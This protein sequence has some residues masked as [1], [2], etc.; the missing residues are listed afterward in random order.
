MALASRSIDEETT[1]LADAY[2]SLVAPKR[3]WRNHN[4][5]LYLILRSFAAGKVGLVDAAIALRNRYSP[6]YCDDIDLYSTAKLVGTDFKQGTG[7]VVYIT[8]LNK[9][10]ANHR[11]L[12]AGIYSYQAVSGTV[13][14]FR[15]RD[16]YVFDP[17][18]ER[19]IAAVSE[20]KGSFPVMQNANIKVFRSD[21]EKISPSFSFSC[22]DNSGLLGY[23][24]ETPL[25]F[26][27]R[28]LGDADRQDHIKELELKIR[29]LP[30]IFECSLVFNESIEPQ[31]YDGIVLGGKELL[32]TITGEPTDEIADLVAR[33]VVYATHKVRDDDVVYCRNELYINGKYPVYFRY[34]DTTDFSLAIAYQYD[35]SKLKPSQVEDAIKALFRGYRRTVAHIDAFSEGDAYKIL[36]S[37]NL[38]NVKILDASVINS[39]GEEVP[40][41]RVPRTRLPRLTG[42]Q[43]SAVEIGGSM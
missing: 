18:E 7:S 30:G 5:K 26:R 1:E 10:T 22:D 19:E 15:V 41:V 40:F 2:D 21:G 8:I 24:D 9:D 38:P 37:L 27:A 20:E 6:L 39:G 42:I 35:Q 14:R 33:E 12:Y 11:T 31:E 36:E 23:A 29:N 4:N 13:F 32:I 16:D 34:H 3:L 17:E 28:I 25:D 43:F